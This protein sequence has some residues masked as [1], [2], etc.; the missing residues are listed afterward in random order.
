MRV[1]LL[2]LFVSGVVY[3]GFNEDVVDQ[4]KLREEREERKRLLDEALGG[5]PSSS[6]EEPGSAE[7]VMASPG[8]T[9]SSSGTSP[10]SLVLTK[11]GSRWHL[12]NFKLELGSI[13][14]Y[15]S[16]EILKEVCLATPPL[17]F[18]RLKRGCL[19]SLQVFEMCL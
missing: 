1:G 6:V 15:I 19:V 5:G 11:R 9:S 4:E 12:S 10:T 3:G 14:I 2:L 13:Y 16:W 7:R 18:E 8:S 17:M